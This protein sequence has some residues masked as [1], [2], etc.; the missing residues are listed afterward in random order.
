[1]KGYDVDFTNKVIKIYNVEAVVELITLLQPIVKDW[2]KYKIVIK[3]GS[4][5]E[6]QS[7]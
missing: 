2:R 6:V 3:N 7:K 5:S 4:K 1:M